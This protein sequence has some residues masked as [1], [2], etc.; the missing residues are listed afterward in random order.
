MKQMYNQIKIDLN[1]NNPRIIQHSKQID[2]NPVKTLLREIEP[3]IGVKTHPPHQSSPVFTPQ[4]KS[5]QLNVGI[6]KRL[7]RLKESS[8]PFRRYDP[9]RSSFCVCLLLSFGGTIKS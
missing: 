4:P 9:F 2:S 6:I 8:D 1:S 7:N 3:F 5:N